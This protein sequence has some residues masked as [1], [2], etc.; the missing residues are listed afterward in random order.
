MACEVKYGYNTFDIDITPFINREGQK[1]TIAVRR[2]NIEESSRWYPG[3]GLY[4]P[5]TIIET[6]AEAL[7]QWGVNAET[8]QLNADGTVTA[9]LTAD[10]AAARN[11]KDVRYSVE[12]DVQ[13]DSRQRTVIEAPVDNNGHAS[14][15][16]TYG[17]ITP[18]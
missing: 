14:V 8:L 11:G 13:T 16:S 9:K 1:N 17:R 3:A 15:I 12:F 10:M 6:G 18:W 4:R 7:S 5:V 2:E